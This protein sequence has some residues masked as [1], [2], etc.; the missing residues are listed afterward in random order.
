[1]TG[2]GEAALPHRMQ[3]ASN[4]DTERHEAQA[5]Q[6]TA[7]PA[8]RAAAAWE[9]RRLPRSPTAEN[10]RSDHVLHDVGPAAQAPLPGR[11]PTAHDAEIHSRRMRLEV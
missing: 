8:M 1:M 9:R 3:R 6:I 2:L 7:E 10:D 11:L 5:A 4:V